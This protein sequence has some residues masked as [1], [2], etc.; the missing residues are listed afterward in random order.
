MGS[1]ACAETGRSEFPEVLLTVQMNRFFSQHPQVVHWA[2][3]MI[4]QP[5]RQFDAGIR[6]ESAYLVKAAFSDFGPQLESND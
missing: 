5:E 6:A 3:L 1:T 4:N 2:V